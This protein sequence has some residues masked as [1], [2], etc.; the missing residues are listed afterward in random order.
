MSINNSRSGF[1]VV[2][3]LLAVV[4]VGL[5]AFLGYTYYNNSRTTDKNSSSTVKQSDAVN[6]VVPAPAVETTSDLTKVEKVLDDT[7][8]D[9]TSDVTQLDSQTSGF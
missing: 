8:L 3:I 7:S 1:H 2:E 6:D 5:L 9:S 4:V